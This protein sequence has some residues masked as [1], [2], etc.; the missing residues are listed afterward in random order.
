[1][2]RT[3]NFIERAKLIHGD[4]YDY[5]LSIYE[6]CMKELKIIC[7][8]HGEFMQTPNAHLS[9]KGCAKCV[10]NK[11]RKRF[12][13]NKEKFIEKS[14]KAHGDRYDYSLVEYVNS[15][16]KVKIIC[17]IHGIFE[18]VPNDHCGY[19]KHGCHPCSVEKVHKQL[20]LTNEE[21]IERSV[22]THS[23]KYNYSKSNYKNNHTHV[24]I[25]CEKHGEFLQIPSNH[26]AGNGCPKCKRSLGEE[27]I[28]LY[29]SSLKINFEMQKRFNDCKGD[30]G[31][32]PFDFYLPDYNILIEYDGI[33]HYFPIETFGGITG[34]EKRQRYDKIKTEWA[35][36]NGYELLRI[37]YD[38]CIL[39]RLMEFLDKYI[40]T[41]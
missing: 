1:M 21:F 9:S 18:Q 10:P 34:F 8:T 41:L 4:E 28:D 13:H 35:K 3:K 26:F 29:L 38:E 25:I 15:Q 14:M 40:T 27:T 7:K 23:N 12:A 36:N 24:I 6:K 39:I 16:T 5:S 32:L 30:V 2:D 22:K 33:Q 17:K 19:K 31:T 20:I 37:R 11:L